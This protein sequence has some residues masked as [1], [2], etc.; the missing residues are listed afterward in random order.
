MSADAQNARLPAAAEATEGAAADGTVLRQELA[1]LLPELRGFARFLV[2]EPTGA[3]D[4]VQ[5]TLLRA[6]AALNQFQPG[7]SLRAWLFTI[8]R[9]AFYEQ[10]R[11][12]RREQNALRKDFPTDNA[13]APQQLSHADLHELDALLW[14]LPPSLREALVLVGARE[15]SHEEAAAICGVPVG[16]MKARVSR[17]RAKLLE[18]RDANSPP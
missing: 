3:D 10:V 1:A 11:R 9:N 18:M 15:L 4:L 7:T 2:R 8:L 12:Q 6:L 16:T 13:G 5:D 14:R 17:A